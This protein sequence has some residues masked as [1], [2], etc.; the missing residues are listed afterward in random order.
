MKSFQKTGLFAI[1]VLALALFSYFIVYQGDQRDQERKEKAAILLPYPGDKLMEL[2]LE[3]TDGTV[4]VVKEGN[5]WKLIEPVQYAADNNDMQN[6]IENI[7][8]EKSLQVVREGEGIPWNVFGLDKPEGSLTLKFADGSNKKVI[9]GSRRTYDNDLY[10]RFD[11]EN[12]VYLVN[13]AWSGYLHRDSKSFRDK[14]LVTVNPEEATEVSIRSPEQGV[15][16]LALNDRKQWEFK[17]AKFDVAPDSVQ[18]WLAVLRNIQVM[19]FVSEDRANFKFPGKVILEIDYRVKGDTKIKDINFINIKI[20][21]P[22][23]EQVLVTV[24]N[25]APVFKV[26][27]STAEKLQVGIGD[28]RDK[29]KP[30]V[31]K[32]GDVA[33]I[34][35]RSS[36]F[37]AQF[38]KMGQGKWSLKSGG[39]EGDEASVE[40]IEN[41][42]K[43][44]ATFEA[45]DFVSLNQVKGAGKNQITLKDPQDKE[46]FWIK[47]GDDYKKQ[48]QGV[49][50]DLTYVLTS[51][52][53]EGMGVESAK[54]KSLPGQTLIKS[55]DAKEAAKPAAAPPSTPDANA[56]AAHK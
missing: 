4:K 12:K 49:S 2:T 8:A 11:G 36:L 31:F 6:L 10:L 50:R 44:L 41:L 55:K 47:W 33:K 48:K 18:E 25:L 27:K 52:D 56:G 5:N 7:L 3:R 19:D 21:E 20:Y 23:D 39:K 53:K 30:F 15:T 38:E 51:L 22:K 42:L 17:G 35:Y 29:K 28:F 46:V 40:Q 24:S 26:S 54:V 37:N 13:A 43:T 14:R 1:F 32:I 45:K 16:Q 9:V 34:Q